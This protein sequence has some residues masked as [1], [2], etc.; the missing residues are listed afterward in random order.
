MTSPLIRPGGYAGRV[1]NVCWRTSILSP[2]LE[3]RQH[4]KSSAG[5][6]RRV[7]VTAVTMAAAMAFAGCGLLPSP[8]SPWKVDVINGDRPL[9]V[10]ITTDV[11]AWSW[12]VPAHAEMVLL[13]ERQAPSEGKID[14]I[15]PSGSCTV[16]DSV[17][18]PMDSFTITP[19][20]VGEDPLA[21]A[22]SITAGASIQAPAN[23]DYFGGCSG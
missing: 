14:L 19:E 11:A 6:L 22:I 4:T 12:L 3:G 5:L 16:Y 13:A 9:I 17:A 7:S 15:D 20:R 23:A 2:A 8:P 18:L 1:S 21:F 10:S